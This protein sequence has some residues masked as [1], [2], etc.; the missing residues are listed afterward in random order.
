MKLILRSLRLAFVKAKVLVFATETVTDCVDE[1]H[2][3]L[4][5]RFDRMST[6]KDIHKSTIVELKV[7]LALKSLL[8]EEAVA[9]FSDFENGERIS[10]SILST[11]D[12]NSSL[13]KLPSLNSQFK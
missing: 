3:Q 1:L 10:S 2:K 5:D 8:E 9:S 13:I 7:V 12:V 11:P 4:S 6:V